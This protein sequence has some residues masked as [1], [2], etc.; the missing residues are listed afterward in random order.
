IAGA[1]LSELRR[2]SGYLARR[3]LETLLNKIGLD[4][5]RLEPFGFKVYSQ[6]DEDGIIEEIFKRIPPKEKRFCEI[7]IENGLECNSLYLI[8]KGW[9]GCWIEGNAS[10]APA[11]QEKFGVILRSRL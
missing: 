9:R 1:L 5:K 11:I 4:Q 7:G 10:H 6:N 3:E 8:H 2:N